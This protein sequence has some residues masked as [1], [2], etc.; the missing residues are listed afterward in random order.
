MP[1]MDYFDSK[2]PKIAKRWGLHPQ[3]L[4][5]PAASECVTPRALAENF[6]GGRGRKK[7]Q[8]LAKTTEK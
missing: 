2:S 7:D 6:P 4:L 8:K 1:K 5:P 3:N